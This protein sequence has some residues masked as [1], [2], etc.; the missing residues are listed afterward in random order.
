LKLNYNLAKYS[1]RCALFWC[2]FE[3]PILEITLC[4]IYEYD[5]F[6][7]GKKRAQRLAANHSIPTLLSAPVQRLAR[8][9]ARAPLFPVF[10]SFDPRQ[11]FNSEI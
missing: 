1:K 11:D 4:Q 7:K 3:N 10:R 8:A 9:E 6:K 5:F 2:F